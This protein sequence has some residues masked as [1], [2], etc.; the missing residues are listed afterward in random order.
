MTIDFKYDV[1][2]G[3]CLCGVFLFQSREKE[4]YYV[5]ADGAVCCNSA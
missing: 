4:G 2:S 3:K 1:L 5:L